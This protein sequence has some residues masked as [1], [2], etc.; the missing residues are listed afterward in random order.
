MN[1]V[2]DHQSGFCFGVEN[3]VDIAECELRTHGTL[4]CL[5]D[6]VHNEQEVDRL[7]K[8]GL[9]IISHETLKELHNT[10]VLIRAHG[11]PPATYELALKNNIELVDASC[12][13]VLKL[14]RRVKDAFSE[15]KSV[16][17]QVVIYGKK[18]HAEVAGLTGQTN[19]EAIVVS[20]EADLEGIDFSRPVRLFS[21]TT[22]NI[23][24][25]HEIIREIGSRMKSA[26]PEMPADFVWKDSI[27]RQV[28]NRA[29]QLR[30]FAKSYDVVIFVSGK[31]SSNGMAL[32][33]V[34]LEENLRT[35][36]VSNPGELKMEWFD[37]YHN[38]GVCGATSTPDW[39]MQEIAGEIKKISP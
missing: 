28:S 13:I 2:I 38:T 4:F 26:N 24:S 22:K 19:D 34:C 27:C 31:K 16:N 14:Q 17:G 35:Y 3:A 39:L 10:R 5:G 8:M 30:S 20:S 18:G 32:F 25:F 36:F 23:G 1:V 6:I 12:S 37:G 7:Q 15:M 21:Q 29:G 11:E 33:N 9:R